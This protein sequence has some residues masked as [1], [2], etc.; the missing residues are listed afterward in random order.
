MGFSF[1]AKPESWFLETGIL[2]RG[3]GRI[4]GRVQPGT[5]LVGAAGLRSGTFRKKSPAPGNVPLLAGFVR[6]GVGKPHLHPLPAGGRLDRCPLRH[7]GDLPGIN[8]IYRFGLEGAWQAGPLSFQAEYIR[9]FLSRLGNYGDS[10][11]EGWYAYMSWFP[12]GGSRKTPRPRP[13]SFIPISGLPGGIRSG[14][15]IQYAELERRFGPG[16]KEQNVTLGLNWNPTP[17]LRIMANYV[18]VFNDRDADGNGTLIGND[19]PQIFQMRMQ[20]KF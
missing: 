9:T 4:P 7:N 12:F 2:G 10:A 8:H 17:K 14:R 1:S 20:W 5:G 13:F 18:L 11:F 19:N 6:L 3:P 16:G 15:A